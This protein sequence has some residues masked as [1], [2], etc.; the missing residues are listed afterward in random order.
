MAELIA[1]FKCLKIC[2][3]PTRKRII[4]FYGGIHVQILDK[5]RD[6]KV[7]DASVITLRKMNRKRQIPFMKML[8]RD[9][10]STAVTRQ[11]GKL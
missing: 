11:N 9:P 1:F 4:D 7:E 8:P 6:K 10:T 5:T 3:L 2:N